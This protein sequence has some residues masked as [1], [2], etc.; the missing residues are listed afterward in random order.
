MA[1]VAGQP[2]GIIHQEDPVQRSRG[3]FSGRDVVTSFASSDLAIYAV[4][5]ARNKASLPRAGT[6]VDGGRGP[7]VISSRLYFQGAVVVLQGCGVGRGDPG[8]GQNGVLGGVVD[9]AVPVT[10]VVRQDPRLEALPP[11]VPPHVVEDERSSMEWQW[12]DIPNW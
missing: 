12:G 7:A 4:L 2:L 5:H 3:G 11:A 6:Q 10:D 1:T 8:C 9:G